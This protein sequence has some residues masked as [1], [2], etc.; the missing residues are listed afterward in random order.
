MEVLLSNEAVQSF[1][2]LQ[3]GLSNTNTD[4]FLIGH[5][6]G[7]MYFVEKIFPSQKGF[8]PSD[9]GYFAMRENLDD[10]IVGFYSFQTTESKLKKILAPIAF[11]KVFL[12]F[13]RDKMNQWVIKPFAIEHDKNFFLLPIDLKSA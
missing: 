4:G 9:R 2:A 11:G 10:K 1:S 3:C 5:R 12:R 6:R 13:D 7:G 8:F